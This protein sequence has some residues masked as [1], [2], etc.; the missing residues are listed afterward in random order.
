[1]IYIVNFLIGG[2]VLLIA[3]LIV[4][5][6]SLVSGYYSMSKEKRKNFDTKGKLI[7]KS[8]L[9]YWAIYL[10]TG[11]LICFI[12]SWESGNL[13]VL[14]SSAVLFSGVIYYR[15]SKYNR[16]FPDHMNADLQQEVIERTENDGL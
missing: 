11:T 12:L 9:D 10:F 3:R 15:I 7:L 14:L 1:M 6:P 8:S 2:L 5:N 16:S 13:F 4:S